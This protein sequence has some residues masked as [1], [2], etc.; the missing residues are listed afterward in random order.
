MMNKFNEADL[1]S[2]S[3]EELEALNAAYAKAEELLADRAW[4]AEKALEVEK[5]LYSAMFEAGL[6]SDSDNAPFVKYTLMPILTKIAKAFS[7]VFEAI[8]GGS[9][10]WKFFANIL[11]QVVEAI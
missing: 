1:S 8:F 6:L 3:A 4:D 9:D 11:K 5:E 2:L 10:Y 7:D